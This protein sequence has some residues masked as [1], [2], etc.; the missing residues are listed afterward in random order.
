[1]NCST[2]KAFTLIEL[3]ISIVIIAI[4][5][6]TLPM[7]LSSANKLEERTINQDIFYKA[8]TKMT[9]IITSSWD[10]IDDTKDSNETN[11][12]LQWEVQNT[13]DASLELNNTNNKWRVG[14]LKNDNYRYFYTDPE[15]NAITIQNNPRYECINDYDGYV[16][17][18]SSLGSRVKTTA[19]V[20]YVSDKVDD[21]NSKTQKAT[22]YLNGGTTYTDSSQST[23]LKRI[24]ILIERSIG[25][26]NMQVNFAYFSSNNGMLGLKTWPPDQQQ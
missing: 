19:K 11:L 12:L 7:M 5:S 14:S 20:Y 15:R 23:N 13:T 25:S 16:S 10:Y 17:D 1:V 21:N 2:K 3:V 6:V 22:W 26:E 9:D 8:T 4:A 18:E 24:N